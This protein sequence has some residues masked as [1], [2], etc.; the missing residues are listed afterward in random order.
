[1]KASKLKKRRKSKEEDSQIIVRNKVLFSIVRQESAHSLSAIRDANQVLSKS[2]FHSVYAIPV[3]G[4][5]YHTGETT[6]S[7][8]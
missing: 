1:V 2:I 7:S 5:W 6:T 4:L 8:R 3:Q